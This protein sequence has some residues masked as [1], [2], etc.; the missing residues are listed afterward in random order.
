MG[1][2]PLIVLDLTRLQ[3]L[4]GLIHNQMADIS[5]KR[6]YLRM[7][8]GQAQSAVCLLLIGNDLPKVTNL[9]HFSLTLTSGIP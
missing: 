1:P 2:N 8:P 9:L 6:Q 4:G 3:R 5:Q 7:V